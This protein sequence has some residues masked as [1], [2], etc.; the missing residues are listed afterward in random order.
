MDKTLCII[1]RLQAKLSLKQMGK[2]ANGQM[3]KFANGL[4]SVSGIN[5]NRSTDNEHR[6]TGFFEK[7]SKF[8]NLSGKD[9]V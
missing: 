9:V 4:S 1:A 7:L 5:H 6:K 3:G 2:W 8:C